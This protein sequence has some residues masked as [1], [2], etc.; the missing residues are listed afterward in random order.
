[1]ERDHAIIIGGGI[2]G[3]LSAQV[4]SAFFHRVTIVDR[5]RFP[6]QP[7]PRTGIPQGRHLHMLM[8]RGLE[9][10][11]EIVPGFG[12]RLTSA[13]AQ[14]MDFGADTALFFPTGWMKRF[15]AGIPFHACTRDLLEWVLREQVLRNPSIQVRQ[16]KVIEGLVFTEDRNTVTGV[17]L[18]DETVHADGVV[19]ASG[20]GS[21]SPDW[22][23]AVGLSPVEET[24]IEAPIDYASFGYQMPSHFSPDWKLMAI[25]PRYPA[26]PRGGTICRV[27]DN[28]WNVL[29]LGLEGD[30]VPTNE[31]GLFGFAQK[32]AAPELYAAL[33]QGVRITPIHRYR[34]NRNRIRHYERMRDWPRQF[35][36]VGDAA[37]ALNPYAGLGMTSAALS[38]LALKR[39]WEQSASNTGADHF[40]QDFQVELARVI[41]PAWQIATHQHLR[42]PH[43]SEE[44]PSLPLGEYLSRLMHNA[45]K[46]P[47]VG[48][49]V[50]Q[51]MHML[52]P[53]ASLFTLEM[54]TRVTGAPAEAR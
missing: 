23:Q 47:E 7:G 48:K 34:N 8:A 4:A 50:L 43:G 25:S 31:A 37:C 33:Q 53:P 44:A 32:L 26:I 54:Q 41:Q 13:G 24:V 30:E 45:V 2:A 51:V 46:K 10:F 27:E 39:T 20:R 5:D 3:L 49:V 9:A 40:A 38:V 29:L 42:W 15:Q 18:E 21:K 35:M 19:D 52:V 14:S 22:L 1:M 17:R 16:E 28:H 6:E 36:V 12:A 11:E